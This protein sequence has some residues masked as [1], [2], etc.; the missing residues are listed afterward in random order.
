M[1]PT[2]LF[3][4]G[5]AVSGP[6]QYFL[7]T[8]HPLSYFGIPPPPA[9]GVIPFLGYDIQKFPLIISL[10]TV[11]LSSKHNFWQLFL[12]QERM[13]LQFAFFA[14][15][16][17]GMYESISSLVFTAAKL[18]PF[19]SERWLYLGA[20]VFVLSVCVEWTAELQRFDFKSEP[21]NKG[22]LFTDGLWRITRHINYTANVY[23]GF[24]FGLAT[25]GLPYTILT[26]GM[27]LSNFIFNAIPSI[28][29]YCA[30]KYGKQWEKYKKDVPYSLI[31]GVY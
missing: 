30:E 10:L 25:G 6:M 21:R 1:F 29:D 12:C 19:W 20:A 23:F 27:Y 2:L 26:A 9:G 14:V 13:S 5:R 4:L 11:F 3:V 31:P 18:N 8:S 7:I 24:G 28:E 16:A 22:K 15:I 17:D